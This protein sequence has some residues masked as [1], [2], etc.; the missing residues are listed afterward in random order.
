MINLNIRQTQLVAGGSYFTQ[1]QYAATFTNWGLA[2]G[3][4]LSAC[5][6]G[7]AFFAGAGNAVSIGAAVIGAALGYNQGYSMGMAMN[8]DPNSNVLNGVFVVQ[9][10]N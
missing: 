6:G 4:M 3:A 9:T 10:Y 7:I 5:T 2:V 8:S 1:E